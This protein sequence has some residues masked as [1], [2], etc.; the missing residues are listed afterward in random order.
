MAR[1]RRAWREGVREEPVLKALQTVH[2][3]GIWRIWAG[4]G[5]HRLWLRLEAG[6]SGG[7]YTGRA[8][9]PWGKPAAYPWR[10]R[11]GKAGLLTCRANSSEHGNRLVPVP[12]WQGSLPARRIGAPTA[13]RAGR[14]GAAVVLRGRE[15]RS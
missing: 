2:R 11:W 13:D 1:G 15:S 12:A 9:R 5:A 6:T 10:C 7:V 4:R 14:G 8:G 3:P